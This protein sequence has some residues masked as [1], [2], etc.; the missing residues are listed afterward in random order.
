MH[1]W[2]STHPSNQ[3]KQQ[4]TQLHF[5]HCQWRER[6]AEEGEGKVFGAA[7]AFRMFGRGRA[8][9]KKGDGTFWG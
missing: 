8:W 2:H 6:R 4:Q 3:P 5:P 7:A 9:F 1:G